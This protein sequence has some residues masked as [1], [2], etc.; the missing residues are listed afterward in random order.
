N[1]VAN[2]LNIIS[3]PN[4]TNKKNQPILIKETQSVN[5]KEFKFN[6]LKFV[7]DDSV[8]TKK[9]NAA[10]DQD[11]KFGLSFDYYGKDLYNKNVKLKFKDDL[12]NEIFTN[13]ISFDYNAI[14]TSGM[15]HIFMFE[16]SNQTNLKLNRYYTF[17]G[18]FDDAGVRINDN[19]NNSDITGNNALK[20][21]LNS[22]SDVS[23][24]TNPIIQ[25]DTSDLT[26]TKVELSFTDPDGIIQPSD[27][28]NNN[29]KI[30]VLD[31]TTNMEKTVF[32]T[33]ENGKIKFT[34]PDTK[35]DHNYKIKKI[36]FVNKPA[37]AVEPI[38]STDNNNI[39]SGSETSI[40]PTNLKI[41]N[42]EKN[43]NNNNVNVKYTFDNQRFNDANARFAALYKDL[44]DNYILSNL[45]TKDT[46]NK[47]NV[48]IEPSK[49]RT[50]NK[51]ILEKIFVGSE[52]EINNLAN[53]T[54]YT[55]VDLAKLDLNDLTDKKLEINTQ[56]T[57]VNLTENYT[58]TVN[59][60]T[61]KFKIRTTDSF[62]NNDLSTNTKAQLK[63]VYKNNET[64]VMSEAIATLMP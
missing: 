57:S 31:E 21:Y 4:N 40:G 25:K 64:N 15:K 33:I 20:F 43:I 49:V 60:A 39:L 56:E 61:L 42:V 14:K 10:S 3:Y 30:T 55:N 24:G 23:F 34:I 38:N 48:S 41:T 29:L 16:A 59:S 53:L 13:V 18:V 47:I 5:K 51:L 58:S 44:D 7:N 52:T 26:S 2:D 62:Y 9:F 17:E 8:T 27:A 22:N 6:S 46:D 36:E 28:N 37:L 11:L 63:L 19:F 50:N 1:K 54:D 12:N 32:G 45:A 35:V